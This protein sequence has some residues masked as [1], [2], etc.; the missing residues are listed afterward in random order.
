M[1]ESELASAIRRNVSNSLDED[2]YTGDLSAQ[3]VPEA[4]I[5]TAQ[6]ST[7][8]PGVLCGTGW[9]D[10]CFRRQDPGCAIHWLA[11]DG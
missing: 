7:R 2:I 9:L 3:L 8:Q 5:S 10:E 11:K 6:V 4:L 1:L